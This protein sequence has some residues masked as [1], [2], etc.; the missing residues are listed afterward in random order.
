MSE[1]GA[2][3]RQWSLNPYEVSL[4]FASRQNAAQADPAAAWF[5]PL[6]PIAPGAPADVAGRQWDYPAGYN[7][8]LQPRPEAVTF[9]TLRALADG[10]DLLRL[11]IETR[12][13]QVARLAGQTGCG[14]CWKNSSSST[15]RRFT[16]S[17]IAAVSSSR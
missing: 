2:G 14:W 3:Q 5:G 10:Y 4:S 1:R 15:R 13:D 12:K 11:V 7:L 8:W 9:G 17:A 6:D 16:C